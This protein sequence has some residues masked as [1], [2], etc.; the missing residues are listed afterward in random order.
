MLKPGEILVVGELTGLQVGVHSP[1][2]DQL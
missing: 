2:A 1:Q